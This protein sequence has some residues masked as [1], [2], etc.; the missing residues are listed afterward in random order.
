MPYH[1][2][3]QRHRIHP[4]RVARH[5]HHPRPREPE[6]LKGREIAGVLD[7]DDVPRLQQRGGEQRQPLLRPRGD[8]HS[9]RAGRQPA[10][11]VPR[12]ERR[13]EHRLALGRRV[14]QRAPR[15]LGEHIAVGGRYPLR[16]EQLGRGQPT[17]EVD[18]FGTRGDGEDVPNG[19]TPDGRDPPGEAG[20]GR[21]GARPA[22][23][24]RT[25]PGPRPRDKPH[26]IRGTLG[27]HGTHP[28]A[29][30]PLRD[31]TVPP[32]AAP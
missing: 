20:H 14:L 25:A 8:E 15:G 22:L 17:R 11:P 1:R 18:D 2:L 5:G 28:T 29:P 4:V 7:Q 24:P 9:V 6:R 12:R 10:R 31:G 30:S 26:V 23:V 13:P 16:V 21:P 27:I 3:L 19:G 32:L